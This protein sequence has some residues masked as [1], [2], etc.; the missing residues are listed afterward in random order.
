MRKYFSE[1][2]LNVFTSYKT[3]IPVEH[4][5]K[6]K[7]DAKYHIY[8]ILSVPRI[9][10]E[11]EKLVV[12]EDGFDLRLKQIV[13][14]EENYIDI[15]KI[16]LFYDFNHKQISFDVKYPYNKLFYKVECNILKEYYAKHK[17][18][19]NCTEQDFIA[20][21]NEPI[22]VQVF[23]NNYCY[24][25]GISLEMEVLYIGQ[26]YGSNGQRLAQD[27]LASHDTLQK[28]LTDCHSKFQDKRIYILLLEMTPVLNSSFY[29][30]A[31]Q[32]QVSE[33]EDQ[34]H[35]KNVMLNL[36]IYNQVINVTEAALINYFKPVYN[37]NFIDNFPCDT[38]KGYRQYYDLDYNCVSVELDLEFDYTPNIQLYT[39]YNR[40]RSSWDFIKYNLFKDPDRKSMFDI[41]VKE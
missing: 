20:L 11:K 18:E 16:E 19:M 40:I 21:C 10:I 36:P 24:Q 9:I 27:R 4:L 25:K 15:K 13:G 23:F 35:F 3:L 28:I 12:Q 6:V 34:E 8:M 37:T 32:Y 2:G 1:F 29:G 39:K 14:E 17:Q 30:G 41:F 22:D 38:H 26:S 5:D 33:E 31:K 7:D